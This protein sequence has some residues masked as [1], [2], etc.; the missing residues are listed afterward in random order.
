MI[1]QILNLSMACL[2]ASLIYIYCR[3]NSLF[4]GNLLFL[5]KFGVEKREKKKLEYVIDLRRKHII[6]AY[7]MCGLYLYY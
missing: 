2:I 3:S 5:Y 7:I 1:D 4:N 6:G